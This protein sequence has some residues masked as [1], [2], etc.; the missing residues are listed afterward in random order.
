MLA[1]SSRFVR[2]QRLHGV[3]ALRRCRICGYGDVVRHPRYFQSA[4]ER[5]AQPVETDQKSA[6]EKGIGNGGK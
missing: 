5:K 6:N 2:R 1:L 4:N 3:R